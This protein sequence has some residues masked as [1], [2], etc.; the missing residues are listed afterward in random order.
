M[1]TS[2]ALLKAAR[3][4]YSGKESY[5]CFAIDTVTKFGPNWSPAIDHL[6]MFRSVGEH[7]IV[8]TQREPQGGWFE[9]REHRVMSLIMAAAIARTN[10]D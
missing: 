6:E 8:E 2:T 5:G 1:K 9:S 4:V 10:G 3:L 7:D